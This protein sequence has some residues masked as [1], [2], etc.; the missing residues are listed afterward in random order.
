MDGRLSAEDC[1]SCPPPSKALGCTL[2]PPVHIPEGLWHPLH[3]CLTLHSPS[4]LAPPLQFPIPPFR[5]S[6]PSPHHPCHL[7]ET[8]SPLR[9]PA[10]PL[11]T[12]LC[13]YHY[14]NTRTALLRAKH[15][16]KS[17]YCCCCTVVIKNLQSYTNLFSAR[18]YIFFLM[19]NFTY[20]S[21]LTSEKFTIFLI[22]LKI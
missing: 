21:L 15:W 12:K 3:N 13:C 4:A 10:I 11:L 8:L 20:F 17:L 6:H 1:P 16:F 5:P 9:N 19:C 2:A 14:R 22:S 18:I 7:P